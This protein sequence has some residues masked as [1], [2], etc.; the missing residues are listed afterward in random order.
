MANALRNNIVNFFFSSFVSLSFSSLHFIQTLTTLELSRNGI[1]DK[2]IQYLADAL[3]NN[4]VICFLSS[5]VA[6]LSTFF[7]HRHSLHLT[8][9]TIKLEAKE[10]NIWL[11]L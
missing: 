2:G 3:R 1:V 4:S 11:M 10:Y 5:S 9:R 6:F 7:S 8:S